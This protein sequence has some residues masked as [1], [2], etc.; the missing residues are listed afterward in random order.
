MYDFK[1]DWG[2]VVF[3]SS[4]LE[5]VKEKAR[6]YKKK[7]NIPSVMVVSKVDGSIHWVK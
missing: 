1:D 6:E 3:S 4:S 2:T 5:E 7:N